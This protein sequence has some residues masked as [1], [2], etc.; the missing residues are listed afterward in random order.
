MVGWLSS[1]YSGLF[2][3][4]VW[5]KQSDIQQSSPMCWFFACYLLPASRSKQTGVLRRA[6]IRM[7]V[8]PCIAH[9]RHLK[10]N[11]QH[12]ETFQLLCSRCSLIPV[13]QEGKWRPE[14]A[15]SFCAG[16]KSAQLKSA[17]KLELEERMK[18][19]YNYLQIIFTIRGWVANSSFL[20]QW[21]LVLFSR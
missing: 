15:I 17:A 16:I 3:C 14:P 1:F 5:L 20:L 7:F 21:Q 10:I 13:D 2:V 6:C 11:H 4:F 19:T 18:Q 8:F 12:A 9:K